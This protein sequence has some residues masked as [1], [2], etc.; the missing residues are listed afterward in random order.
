MSQSKG[1]AQPKSL[2][3]LKLKTPT[4]TYE[5]TLRRL[6][7][8]QNHLSRPRG[9]RL[10]GKVCGRHRRRFSERDRK[11]DISSVC[12]RRSRARALYLLDFDGTNLPNLKET[13]NAAY[14]DVQVEV[15]EG[16]AADETTISTIAGV[17]SGQPSIL[18]LSAEEWE[19]MM[20]INTTSCFL[21]VKYAAPAMMKPKGTG[22]DTGGSIIMTA[23]VAGLRSGA[24]PAHLSTIL[25]SLLRGNYAIQT[26]ALTVSA[27]GS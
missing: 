7:K 16:D 21:A 25:R 23:S 4:L 2:D 6:E 1:N 15:T 9:Q 3:G 13:I 12:A 20:R 27:L 8:I 14:P 18:D 24:G 19:E 10:Q 11:G 5:Q 22:A 26:F 17:A